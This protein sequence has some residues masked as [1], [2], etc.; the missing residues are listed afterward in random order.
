MSE[1]IESNTQKYAYCNSCV[2]HTGP[3]GSKDFSIFETVFPHPCLSAQ[4]SSAA[5]MKGSQVSGFHAGEVVLIWFYGILL[6]C[7]QQDKHEATRKQNAETKK[8][9]FE[10]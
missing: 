2:S 3:V 1:F 4:A 8:A 6:S 9:L 5:C 7:P 10:K